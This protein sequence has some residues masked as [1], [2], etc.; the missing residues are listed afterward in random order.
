MPSSL[1][2]ISSALYAQLAAIA[3]FALRVSSASLFQP[4]ATARNSERLGVIRVRATVARVI[5]A[6]GIDQTGL[7]AARAMRIMSAMCA[8]PPFP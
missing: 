4:P 5:V 8:S 3:A 7:P 6:L 1:R 2:V